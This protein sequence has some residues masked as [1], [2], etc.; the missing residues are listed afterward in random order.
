MNNICAQLIVLMNRILKYFHLGKVGLPEFIV[1]MYLV[2]EG[3]TYWG[4]PLRLVFLLLLDFY[5]LTRQHRKPLNIPIF[6]VVYVFFVLH[7]ILLWIYVGTPSYMFNVTVQFALTVGSIAIIGYNLDYEKLINSIYWVA[8]ISMGGLVYHYIVI[9]SGGT[10]TPIKLPFLPDPIAEIN[11]YSFEISRPTSFFQ[12]PAAFGQFMLIPLFIALK[13]KKVGSIILI[14]SMM[15]LSS[16][17]NAIFFAVGM[18]LLYSLI[19]R[20]MKMTNK[21]V[22]LVLGIGLIYS[23]QHFSLFEQGIE[24]IDNTEFSE[25]VRVVNGYN[26]VSAMPKQYLILGIPAANVFD[27][28]MLD[29]NSFMGSNVIVVEHSLYM[30][31]FWRVLVKYGIIGLFLFLSMY[32]AYYKRDKSLLPIMVILGVQLFSQSTFFDVSQFVFLATYI[33]YS[34]SN[35]NQNLIPATNGINI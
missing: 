1:A 9:A 5:F 6:Y 19:G 20:K 11:R 32:V 15:F 29:P 23:V 10:P 16:S 3:Y 13:E 7:E 21:I 18:V 30:T 33:Y 22:I 8:I 26:Y 31:T 2:L 4:V 12:E 14:A 24:K 25:N 35:N 17:T 27:Y 34:N 28:Y